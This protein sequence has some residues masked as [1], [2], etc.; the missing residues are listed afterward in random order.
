ML[1]GAIVVFD[2]SQSSISRMYRQLRI[3]HH[4]TQEENHPGERPDIPGLTAKG[5]ERWATLMILAHPEEEFE[6]FKAAALNMPINNPD[7]KKERFPKDISRRLFPKHENLDSRE[8]LIA[9]MEAHAKI[10]VERP[11]QE[12]T[13]TLRAEQMQHLGPRRGSDTQS[14]QSFTDAS[15]ASE[16]APPLPPPLSSEPGPSKIERERKP[17]S[18]VPDAALIDDTNPHQHP[19]PQAI[20]RERKPYSV[21]PGG[22]RVYDDPEAGRCVPNNPPREHQPSTS[23]APP[24][25]LRRSSSAASRPINIPPPP[26]GGPASHRLSAAEFTPPSQIH[27]MPIPVHHRPSV[28]RRH[29]PSAS[30]GD[31]RRSDGDVRSFQPG[32]YEPPSH[33]AMREGHHHP[34]PKGEGFDDDSRRYGREGEVRRG[35]TYMAGGSPNRKYD[36]PER[37]NTYNEEDYYRVPPRKDP[38]APT[39]RQ[40]DPNYR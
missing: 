35:D 6:R 26:P 30:V 17:Y 4:L 16:S 24:A 28:R 11:T 2:D 13:P 29:S 10:T 5:F 32:S 15:V 12:E 33:L 20:E 21:A 1:T 9:A 19:V 3:Q 27:Q 25:G 39:Y 38:S 34:V 14:H 7:D 18:R 36:V 23:G 22:G 8:V 40:P 31:F 37:R